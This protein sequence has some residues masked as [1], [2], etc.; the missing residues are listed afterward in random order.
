MTRALILAGGDA[1]VTRVDVLPGTHLVALSR[2]MLASGKF[3]TIRSI[4]P[5]NL[6]DVIFLGEGLDVATAFEIARASDEHY[7]TVDLV[8]VGSFDAATIVEAMRAGIRE[9]VLP[10]VPESTLVEVLRRAENH[11]VKS[12][13]SAEAHVPSDLAPETTRT[14]TIVSPK[15]GVGKTSIATNMAIGY[16]EKCPMNVV[17]VDLDLQFGDVAST[18]NITPG[19]TIEDALAP[20]AATDNLVLKTLL[21]VHPGNFYVLCGANS[22]A[23][24]DLVTDRQI[25]RLIEQLSSQF[26]I[27]IIDTAAGLTEATLSALEVTDDVI[28]VSTM[29]VACVRGMR[30]ATELLAE[31]GLLP[32]SR[33]LALNLVDKSSGMKVRDVEAVVGLPVEVVIP[34]T[35]EVQ[36]AANQGEP[37]MMKKKRGGPFVKA[38]DALIAQLE[39]REH[40]KASAHER[41]EVA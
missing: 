35:S 38:I 12:D 18:L 25:K 40:A 37:L 21:A 32:A 15:G 9:V 24:G 19:A 14:I 7:P 27:I 31:L 11:R 10:D 28:L 36:L 20:E 8:L 34:R 16:A 2:E 17:L 1:F 13:G 39:R 3:D 4:D 33:L 6:P 26:Q 41:L 22:P 5:Q 23:A 30:K 29:D